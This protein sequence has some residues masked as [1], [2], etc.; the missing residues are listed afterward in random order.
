MRLQVTGPAVIE[1]GTTTVIV[2]D[3][4][5]CIVDNSGSFVMY[6]R[7]R[8]QELKARLAL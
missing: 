2:L 8:E 5:D 4:Y 6:L 3:Q 1:F 7:A